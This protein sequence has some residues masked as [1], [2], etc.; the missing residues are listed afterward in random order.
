M[1]VQWVNRPNA[2]FRG[3]CG[4]IAGGTVDVGMPVRVLP[5]GQVT[6]CRQ[7]RDVGGRKDARRPPASQ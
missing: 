2:D 3:Y 5:S 6:A 1:P 4:L 7:H